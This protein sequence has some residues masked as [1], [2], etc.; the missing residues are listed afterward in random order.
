MTENNKKELR[1][2]FFKM[3]LWCTV[4]YGAFGLCVF[5]EKDALSFLWLVGFGYLIS[6]GFLVSII[7]GTYKK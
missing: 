2:A 7:I 6:V 4:L 5:I 1:I 3:I